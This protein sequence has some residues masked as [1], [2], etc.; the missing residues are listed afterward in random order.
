MVALVF[1]LNQL[2]YIISF[3]PQIF[4][5]SLSEDRS[6]ALKSILDKKVEF[7]RKRTEGVSVQDTSLEEHESK[8]LQR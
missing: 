1:Q 6:S 7:H 4:L 5:I 8:S 2:K 3:F